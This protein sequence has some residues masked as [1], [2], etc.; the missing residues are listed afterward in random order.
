MVDTCVSR[1]R[2]FS[3]LPAL[4]LQC[5]DTGALVTLLASHAIPR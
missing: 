4:W 5:R 2:G 3:I 1:M